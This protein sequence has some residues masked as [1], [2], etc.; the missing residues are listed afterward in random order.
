MYVVDGLLWLEEYPDPRRVVGD[1]TYNG[2]VFSA[3][4]LWDYWV[5]TG[6]ER[7]K[8]LLQ[9]ALTTFRDVH[10]P[11][12]NRNWRSKYCLRHAMDAGVYHTVH[13]NEHVQCYAITR[14]TIFARIAELYYTDHPPTNSGGKILFQAGTHTGYRFD[15]TGTVLA[16]KTV[17]LPRHSSAPASERCRVIGQDGVWYRIS[18][19]LWAGY[20]VREIPGRS[21]QLGVSGPLDY[22]VPRPA[23]VVRA[24]LVAYTITAGGSMTSVVTNLRAGDR[25]T[26]DQRAVL[27]G[28]DHLRIA[29]GAYAGKWVGYSAVHR[30]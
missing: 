3:Y 22:L 21:Y 13:I 23:T 18:A 24:P 11:M 15:G 27:N 30:L 4:G 14:D 8:V 6:D 16:T 25:I 1:R 10:T 17:S 7:A 5:L 28:V 26:L 2:H 20:H 29:S 9:G 19:G 12:S